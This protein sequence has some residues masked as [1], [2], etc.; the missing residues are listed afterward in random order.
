MGRGAHATLS[1]VPPR[2]AQRRPSSPACCR[3]RAAC[4]CYCRRGRL[5]TTRPCGGGR[6]GR[7]GGGS[8]GAGRWGRWRES[9]RRGG[10]WA[11]APLVGRRGWCGSSCG[12]WSRLQGAQGGAVG[13]PGLGRGA[14]VAWLQHGVVWS[15]VVRLVRYG[16]RGVVWWTCTERCSAVRCGPVWMWM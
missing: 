16:R 11:G 10:W 13:G 15:G 2:P 7:A 3:P 12:G 4:R 1:L 5:G 14:G 6:R 8:R 9:G